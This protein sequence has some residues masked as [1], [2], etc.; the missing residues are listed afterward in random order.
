[1]ARRNAGFATR[2]AVERNF[3][4]ILFSL[5]RFGEGDETAVVV[6]EV[7]LLLVM[8]LGKAG[9]RGLELFL[10]G[11][12][13]IDQITGI[14]WSLAFKSGKALE[15]GRHLNLKFRLSGNESFL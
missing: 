5:T 2:A 13:L 3:E 1:M 15:R 11:E 6:C 10:L 9:D 14:G 4:G 7:R 8:D 12:E